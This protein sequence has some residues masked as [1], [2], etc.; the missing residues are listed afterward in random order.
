[1]II[2]LSNNNNFSRTSVYILN[3]VNNNLALQITKKNDLIIQHDNLKIYNIIDLKS[4]TNIRFQLLESL[5]IEIEAQL[6]EFN[7]QSSIFY[8]FGTLISKVQNESKKNLFEIEL[9]AKDKIYYLVTNREDV[10]IGTSYW[11]GLSG[12]ILYD[13]SVLEEGSIAGL[14]SQ[15]MLLAQKSIY[16]TDS[17]QLLTN[18]ADLD[19]LKKGIN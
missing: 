10:E 19:K 7:T 18:E 12:A 2:K 13:G 3:Y 6:Q 5:P 11:F 16:N 8:E 15:G 14:F 17:S 9:K 4:D 1:M